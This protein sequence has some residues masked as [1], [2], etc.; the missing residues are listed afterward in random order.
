MGLFMNLTVIEQNGWKKQIQLNKA[1]VRIGTA[2]TNDIQLSS[3]GVA[4]IH[5][6]IINDPQS[7]GKCTLL[8]MAALVMLV[9]GD[10][11]SPIESGA[12]ADVSNGDELIL[13][14]Y[15]ILFE[16]PLSS[17]ILE[18]SN[19]IEASLVVPDAVLRTDFPAVG[20]LHLKNLGAHPNCQFHVA[21]D[22]LAATCFRID[23]LPILYPGSEEDVRIQFFHHSII[24]SAGFHTIT[25][26]ITAPV[27][28]PGERVILHQELY[29]SPS[30][31][32]DINLEDDM[33][34]PK[35]ESHI[36]APTPEQGVSDMQS[37]DEISHPDVDI[38]NNSPVPTSS[39]AE[40]IE[41]QNLELPVEP[42]GEVVNS[43][44]ATILDEPEPAVPVQ[45]E[46]VTPKVVRN[47]SET[48]WDESA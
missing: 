15:H 47:P 9:S 43:E 46:N 30:L 25:A 48:Y 2:P 20:T 40:M 14:E 28:Y 42:S 22:G 4:P 18:S 21:I 44:D 29:I 38:N 11:Q 31:K 34:V 39:E 23:P 27:S 8:N 10:K 13:D 41:P 5:L 32:T 24:P 36:E 33:S 35:T 3:P 45:N 6:Q 7:L 37:A 1:V 16:L 19:Q 12:Q 26:T 17:K